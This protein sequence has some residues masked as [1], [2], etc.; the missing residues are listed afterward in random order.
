MTT[1]A[2]IRTDRIMRTLHLY[3]GL[4]LMPWLLL[5]ALSALC[6]NHGPWI[7]Q[8][9]GIAPLRWDVVE[10]RE[11]ATDEAF[12][13]V[14]S[15]Q[16]QAILQQ[17]KLE[18]PHFILPQSPAGTMVIMRSCATGPYRITWRRGQ[19]SLV[20]E[21]QQTSAFRL[22]NS[23]HY[24][25]GYGQSYFAQTAWAVIVDAVSVSMAVWVVSGVYLWA[26]RPSKRLLGGICAA[27]GTL[28]FVGLVILLC[29]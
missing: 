22:L 24:Q 4:F 16:A 23:L 2:L 12:P 10:K 21:K 6:L 3:T 9:I 8:T 7:M 14:S 28:L 25:H 29:L 20:V 26:R 13:S 1:T 27:A 15:E 5:Y 11:L 19:S 17:L 18:G